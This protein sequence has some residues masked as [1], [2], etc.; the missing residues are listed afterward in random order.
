MAGGPLADL[1]WPA[2]SPALAMLAG[3]LWVV[4]GRNGQGW[5]AHAATYDAVEQR[6]RSRQDLPHAPRLPVAA[7]GDAVEVLSP[8]G[9]GGG[10]LLQIHQGPAVFYVLR[11]D[12][13]A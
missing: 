8:E 6:F 13:K 1:P 11:K 10:L 12:G 7:A 3:T 5:T 4:G 9:L 2:S